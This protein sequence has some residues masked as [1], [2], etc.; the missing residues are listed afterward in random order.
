MEIIITMIIIPINI[1]IY[2][3]DFSETNKT[4]LKE[5]LLEN[6]QKI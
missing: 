4:F 5:N 2:D 1:A 3:K 6:L